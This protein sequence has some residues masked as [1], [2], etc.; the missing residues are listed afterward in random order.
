MLSIENRFKEAGME[1]KKTVQYTVD[2]E[3][4]AKM[5]V[6]DFLIRIVRSHVKEIT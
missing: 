5:S 1:K 3:F 6:K 4:L 2:R